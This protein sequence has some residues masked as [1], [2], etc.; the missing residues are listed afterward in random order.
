LNL[1]YV[2][3]LWP[4]FLSWPRLW[5]FCA[6]AAQHV[7][8]SSAVTKAVTPHRVFISLLQVILGF[9]SAAVG[10]RLSAFLSHAFYNRDRSTCQFITAHLFDQ[11]CS[12]QNMRRELSA[13][14]GVSRGKRTRRLDHAVPRELDLHLILDNYGTHK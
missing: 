13:V 8:A 2:L 9:P 12:A 3:S 1:R 4:R 14:A 6:K 11:N 10:I 5:S 7:K